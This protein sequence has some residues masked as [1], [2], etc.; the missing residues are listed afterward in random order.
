MTFIA[1]ETDGLWSVVNSERIL[2]YLEP[3]ADVEAKLEAEGLDPA[4]I[5]VESPAE[6]FYPTLLAGLEATTGDVKASLTE[7]QQQYKSDQLNKR[8]DGLSSVLSKVAGDV[9]TISQEIVRQNAERA[10]QAEAERLQA[11]RDA[12][13]APLWAEHKTLSAELKVV[14]AWLNKQLNFLRT[15]SRRLNVSMQDLAGT[16]QYVRA[17]EIRKRLAELEG[18]LAA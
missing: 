7:F 13:L 3:R 2:A 5:L 17:N 16:P 11:E 9:G 10:E 15:K 1:K 8:M 12:E 14:T 4:E 18:E 6:S